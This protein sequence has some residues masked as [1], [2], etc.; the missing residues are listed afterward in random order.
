MEEPHFDNHYPRRR[1]RWTPIPTGKGV[2]ITDKHIK[3]M[4]LLHRHGPLPWPYLYDLTKD[5]PGGRSFKAAE[6]AFR[7][8]F[9][10]GGYLYLPEQQKANKD[11]RSNFRVFDLTEKAE[12]LLIHRGLWHKRAPIT[13]ENHWI[14]DF[15]LGCITASIQIEAERAGYRFIFHD[16]LLEHAKSDGTFDVEYNEDG[17]SY[18]LKP[19]RF[20]G[21]WSPKGKARFFVIEKDRGTERLSQ[22][23]PK[24]KRRNQKKNFKTIRRN[25]S[26]YRK[27][28][29]EKRYKDLLGIPGGLMVL[30]YTVSPIRMRNMMQ[31]W[32][33]VFGS[34]IQHALFSYYPMFG[35]PFVPPPVLS[36]IFTK[37]LERVGA[38][39]FA[40]SEGM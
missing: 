24:R 15:A 31:I 27:F 25:A 33:E 20:C 36:K 29:T 38:E 35:D 10:E 13:S 17:Y 1:S 34:P 7:V 4:E 18:L 23:Q 37:P 12:D 21:I 9:H 30:N 8:L 16:E 6:R 40:L 22:G 39:P 28:I 3:W 5:M 14:H 19:D 11:R 26:Q 32:R 2:R